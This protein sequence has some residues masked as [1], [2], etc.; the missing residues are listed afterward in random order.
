M[1]GRN[2]LAMACSGLAL[3]AAAGCAHEPPRGSIKDSA[4]D[5]PVPPRARVRGYEKRAEPT[6][7]PVRAAEPAAPPGQVKTTAADI[8]IAPPRPAPEPPPAVVVPRTGVEPPRPVAPPARGA[9]PAVPR[10]IN[11]P[12]P[13]ARAPEALPREAAAGT[14]GAPP[15]GMPGINGSGSLTQ[16]I[17]DQARQRIAAG[18]VIRARE[19]LLSALNGARPEVLH[20]LARTFDPNF[21]NRISQPNAVPEPARARALYEE[22]VRLGAKGAAEDLTQLLKSIAQP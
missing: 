10:I 9:E 8:R 18:D 19:W 16:R 20:E 17:M 2:L 14:P 3:L 1:N 7:R 4:V 13:P 22:A 11:P 15:A 12:A 5:E 6:A 21:L